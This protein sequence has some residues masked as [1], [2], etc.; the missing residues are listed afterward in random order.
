MNTFGR[1]KKTRKPHLRPANK[2]FMR[3]KHKIYM[4]AMFHNPNCDG[5]HC[6]HSKG[7]VRVLP[8]GGGG[9]LILCQACYEHEINW[10]KERNREVASPFGLPTWESLRVYGTE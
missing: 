2:G 6:T 5:D 10:R 1:P 3:D 7:E 4:R 8:Y 9:N